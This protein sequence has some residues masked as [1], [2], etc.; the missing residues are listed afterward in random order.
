MKRNQF[1]LRTG[2]ALL[3]S[4]MLLA[5]CSQAGGSSSSASGSDAR[6]VPNRRRQARPRNS[7]SCCAT[8][9]A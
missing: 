7:P 9:R 5:G 2:A 3:A 8:P 6:E 4:A 1:L